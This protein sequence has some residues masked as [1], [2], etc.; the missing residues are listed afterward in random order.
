MALIETTCFE[1]GKLV[2]RRWSSK[3][4]ST[5]KSFCTTRC[6][7]IY[8]K[9]IAE[10]KRKA[11]HEIPMKIFYEKKCLGCDS[12][13]TVSDSNKNQRFCNITCYNEYKLKQNIVTKV[14]PCQNEI[15]LKRGASG[16]VYF[17]E[18][19]AT[20]PIKVGYSKSGVYIRLQ[21]IQT[22]HPYPIKPKLILFG[23][24]K[25]VE[26]DFHNYLSK[27]R[28]QGEWFERGPTIRVINT[29]IKSGVFKGINSL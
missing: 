4:P 28:V 21:G 24:L 23:A 1:C 5:R 13:F 26:R 14:K 19:D 18:I 15:F 7:G 17:V 11:G 29:I 6:Q 3:T 2:R 12:L 27:Y 9:R 22:D 20:S 8:L 25:S 10:E 16:G